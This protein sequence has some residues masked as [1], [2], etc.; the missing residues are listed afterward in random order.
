[1]GDVDEAARLEDVLLT[2]AAQSGEVAALGRLLE[3]HRGGMRAV[4]LSILG[5]G[6]DADDVMQDAALTALLRIGDVRDPAAVGAWL[7]MIVRNAG[8]LVLREAILV[9]PVGE[10]P[11][12]AAQL[13][14][15]QWLERNALR[16]WVWEALAE[17]TPAL[18][19]P[20]LLRYFAAEVTSYE[21]IADAC[22]I[23]VG[24][25]RSRLSR[26]RAQMATALAA[27]ADTPHGPAE[28][29]IRAGRVEAYELLAA[30]D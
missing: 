8:R 12:I 15:E 26:G 1:M 14:P 3:R 24:T 22:G 13:G 17:L 19:M 16:D 7:R 9:R 11:V 6:A 10:L 2:R 30:A 29:R 18:R 5:P 27:T 4:A 21:R 23:P 25:V 28:Q 20:L